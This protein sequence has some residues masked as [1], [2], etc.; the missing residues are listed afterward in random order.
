MLKRSLAA[1]AFL[2]ATLG[3]AGSASALI[4]SVDVIDPFNIDLTFSGTLIGPEPGLVPSGIIFIDTPVPGTLNSVHSA[5]TGDASLGSLPLYSAFSGFTNFPYDGTLQLRGSLNGGVPFNIGDVFS[6]TASISFDR[7]HGMTQSL[8]DGAGMPIFW[9]RYTTPDNFGTLQGY[10]V[11][12]SI[13]EPA[14]MILFG[15]GLVGLAW[16]RRRRAA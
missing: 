6:G 4:I 8:F 10:A 12:A 3:G 11:S 13:P 14:T 7:D 9:G 16:V 2:V 5:I 15:T 1:V